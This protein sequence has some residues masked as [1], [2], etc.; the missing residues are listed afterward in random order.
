MILLLQIPGTSASNLL[1][2]F[3]GHPFSHFAAEPCSLVRKATIIS[4]ITQPLTKYETYIFS[5]QD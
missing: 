3:A 4:T 1:A 5:K 2:H